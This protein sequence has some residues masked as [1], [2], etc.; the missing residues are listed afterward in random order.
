LAR[1]LASLP[2]PVAIMACNDI[3]GQQVMNAC[4]R[5]ELLVPEEV[6]VIGVDNDEIFCELSEPPLTSVALDTSRIG[7]EAAALLERMMAGEKPPSHPVLIPPL[8]VVVRRSS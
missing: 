8:G 4:R 1:W 7:Y 5:L 2:K 6:A 3:R